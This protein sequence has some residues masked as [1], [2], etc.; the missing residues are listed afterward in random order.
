MI[1]CPFKDLILSSGLNGKDFDIFIIKELMDNA[2]DFIEQNAKEFV[3]GKILLL[4][5]IITEEERWKK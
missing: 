2:L 5:V 3:N 1:I 4:D